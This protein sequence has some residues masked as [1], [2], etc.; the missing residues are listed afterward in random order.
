MGLAL[1]TFEGL[2]IVYG[3]LLNVYSF[4]HLI[5]KKTRLERVFYGGIMDKERT[6]NSSWCC[7]RIEELIKEFDQNR[8]SIALSNVSETEDYY[9]FLRGF[10]YV[11]DTIKY[12]LYDEDAQ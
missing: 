4:R 9:S 10:D 7:D 3:F 12:V 8:E 2:E 6:N 11:L 1:F 5:I